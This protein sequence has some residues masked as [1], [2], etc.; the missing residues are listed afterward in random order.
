MES[1]SKVWGEKQE[2]HTRKTMF[3]KGIAAGMPIFLG[4]T[5]IAIAY[6][7][8]GQQSGLAVLEIVLMSIMVFAGAS[9]F[10]GVKMIMD[11]IGSIE[12]ILATFV[13][14]FRHFVMSLSLMNRFKPL[15]LRWKGILSFGITD[16]TF[17]MSSLFP[18]EAHQKNGA[19]FYA[20]LML[21]AYSSWVTGSLVG[22]M[23]GDVIPP[24]LSNSMM[25]ALYAMFIGLLVPSIK[26]EYKVG[27]IAVIS[28][29]INYMLTEFVGLSD[30]W[31]IVIATILGGFSGVF[32]LDAPKE[33]ESEGQ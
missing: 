17:A 18:K 33:K 15:S 29:V 24:V 16:E 9:Q 30:G 23:L 7:V 19:W 32:L 31:S 14:N 4:Y 12:I 22:G 20:G 3:K 6:G 8:L 13:L 1:V 21:I 26:K 10:M 28:I 2:I 27:I 5:P 25:I 11:G